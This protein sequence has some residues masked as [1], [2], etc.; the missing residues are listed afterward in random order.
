MIN[1][2]NELNSLIAWNDN[3]F[4][5]ISEVRISPLD[6][7][8]I[9]SDATYE[10]MRI[11]DNQILHYDLHYE[12]FKNSCEFYG[13]SVIKN[14]SDIADVL[15]SK[16]NLTDAFLWMCVWRGTPP[17]GSPRDLSGPQHEFMYVKPYYPIS[18]KPITLCVVDEF[19]RSHGYQ[20]YKNFCWR[21]LTF[22]QRKANE[23]GFDSGIVKDIFGNISEGPGFSICFVRDNE[24]YTPM[25]DVL[26]SITVKIIEKVCKEN[27]IVFKRINIDD[28][29]QYDEAFI[30][31]TS[32]GITLV[33]QIENTFYDH[34]LS[35]QLKELIC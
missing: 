11:K 22:A 30:C 35:S 25:S 6:F 4:K 9:H 26:D 13:F 8:F 32:G 29:E 1:N 17:S 27:N 14:I 31:S 3:Q 16:N 34:K 18:S 5:K 24:I 23:R 33:S 19:K 21:E 10:V 7:G 2:L 28:Y 12:R 20:E 15:R